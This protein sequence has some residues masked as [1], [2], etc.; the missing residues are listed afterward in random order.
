M[1]GS[2]SPRIPRFPSQHHE[3]SNLWAPE[4]GQTFKAAG[5]VRSNSLKQR[6]ERIE[7]GFTTVVTLI[8]RQ[9]T[10]RRRQIHRQSWAQLPVGPPCWNKPPGMVPSH[11]CLSFPALSKAQ[12]P[13]KLQES[14]K[15]CRGAAPQASL[16][17]DP[18]TD[19]R[20]H[21]SCGGFRG[22]AAEQAPLRQRQTSATKSPLSCQITFQEQTPA[23]MLMG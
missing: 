2:G 4:P 15:P 23:Q 5:G 14:S 7:R 20:E 10:A 19:S 17:P 16:N 1:L 18:D 8:S 9:K 12:T 6:E 22:R 11:P 21:P 3:D 13:L